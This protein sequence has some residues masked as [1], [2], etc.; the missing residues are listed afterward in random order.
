[1]SAVIDRRRA[2]D[3]TGVCTAA[4]VAR[5]VRRVQQD[6]RPAQRPRRRGVDRSGVWRR[7]AGAP[8]SV[9][10]R[11]A[12]V[13]RASHA[14]VARVRRPAGI[15]VVVGLT[16]L[17]AVFIFAAAQVRSI[18]AATIPDSVATV[19]VASGDTLSSIAR[20]SAPDA[21]VNQVVDRIIDLN[22]LDGAAVR[23]GQSLTVP[24]AQA[25]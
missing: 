11:A 10:R 22:G 24:S 16:V 4:P 17:L 7:P 18:G 5:S 20:E 21:P 15:G 19:E 12:V 2:Q 14:P 8:A 1:M 3:R 25:R 9:P 6:P 13:S 23:T